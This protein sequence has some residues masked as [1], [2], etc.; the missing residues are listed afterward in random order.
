MLGDTIM[1]S[2]EM[3][4]ILEKLDKGIDDVENGRVTLHEDTMKILVQRY[5]EYV[6]QKS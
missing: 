6:S 2:D 5:N 1:S 3:P 4:E